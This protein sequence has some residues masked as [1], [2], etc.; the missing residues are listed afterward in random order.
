M[1]ISRNNYTECKNY[2]LN[3]A[4]C[5]NVDNRKLINCKRLSFDQNLLTLNNLFSI[6]NYFSNYLDNDEVNLQKV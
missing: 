3:E 1:K 2:N 4:I 6:S 5:I